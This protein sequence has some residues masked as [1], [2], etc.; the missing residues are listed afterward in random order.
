MKKDYIRKQVMER[1]SGLSKDERIQIEQMLHD[2]LFSSTMWKQASTIG[3]T[4]HQPGVEWDT[5]TIIKQAWKEGKRVAVPK[6]IHKNR[7]MYFY[8]FRSFDELE[9]VYYNLK[10]PIPRDDR[11]VHKQEIDLLIVPGVVFDFEGYRI[12]FGGGYY[13]RFLADY[14]HAT[15]SLASTL[16]LMEYL[17][18]EKHD[19]AVDV[20]ITEKEMI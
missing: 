4:I 5:E 14:I 7:T 20:L 19:I 3:V 1:L 15:V 12:G 13:D 11:F 9:V 18:K 10:E 8:D 16:Q 17:P 6:C 2:R